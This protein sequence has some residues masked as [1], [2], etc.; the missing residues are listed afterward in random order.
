MRGSGQWIEGQCD[1]G[2]VC[3]AIGREMRK[4]QGIGA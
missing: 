2:K 4:R 3:Q 1:G